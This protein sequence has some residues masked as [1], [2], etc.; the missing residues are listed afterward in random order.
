MA[1]KS[2]VV[3]VVISGLALAGSV[4]GLVINQNAVEV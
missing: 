2:N 3:A 4:L 1:D